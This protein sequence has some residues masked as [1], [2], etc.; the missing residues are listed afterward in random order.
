[1]AKPPK[2]PGRAAKVRGL[3]SATKA[4]ARGTKVTVL[5][6]KVIQGRIAKPMVFIYIPRSFQA[7]TTL[8]S[9]PVRLYR[10]SWPVDLRTR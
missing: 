8:M 1:M 6:T 5:R 9:P 10:F 7:P 4:V 3:T 2:R